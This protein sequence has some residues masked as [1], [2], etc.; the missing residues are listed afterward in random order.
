M[1]QIQSSRNIF[2]FNTST[3]E[4]KKC[5]LRVI[6]RNIQ[7]HQD[8]LLIL[9]FGLPEW[10]IRQAT[11]SSQ[12]LAGPC[13]NGGWGCTGCGCTCRLYK[14][15]PVLSS[16]P[17][18]LRLISGLAL[19]A[20]PPLLPQP[21]HS[22]LGTVGVGNSCRI[23]LTSWDTSHNPWTLPVH[24]GHSEHTVSTPSSASCK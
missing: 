3:V 7:L 1:Y 21:R 14:V 23:P 8:W 9:G 20:A 4:N 6:N 5:Q 24:P 13:G 11:L 22:R 19:R 10:V 15:R 17:P 12:P 2:R 16:R 18:T